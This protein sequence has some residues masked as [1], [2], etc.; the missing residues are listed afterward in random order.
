MS[1]SY[2]GWN[3]GRRRP[4]I[5]AADLNF[6]GHN[7]LLL[8]N[9]SGAINVWYDC[10]LWNPASR[11]YE[12][13]EDLSAASCLSVDPIRRELGS[14]YRFG[15]CEE[16]ASFCRWSGTQLLPVRYFYKE[17]R[18]AADS[19]RECITFEKVLEGKHWVARPIEAGD[20]SVLELYDAR[21]WGVQP[22]TVE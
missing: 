10:W 13:S 20:S 2:G 19:T 16:S 15:A 21:G 22:A 6:D 4:C 11:R 7:D 5:Q 14:Y 17:Q 18:W 12:F 8:F 3:R 9:N 1:E